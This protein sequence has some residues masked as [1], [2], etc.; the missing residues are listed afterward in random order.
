MKRMM[1]LGSLPLFFFIAFSLSDSE[2]QG[3]RGEEEAR[4]AAPHK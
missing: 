1:K 2:Y 4:S 3:G